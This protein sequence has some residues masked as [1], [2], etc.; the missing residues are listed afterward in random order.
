MAVFIFKLISSFYLFPFISL[1]LFIFTFLF[2][3]I[4]V[5][6]SIFA[7][8]F[9][10]IFTSIFILLTSFLIIHPFSIAI[11]IYLAY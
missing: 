4:F 7:S 6:I 11:L 10:L 5:F 1:S 8:K 3:V 9:T 2:K